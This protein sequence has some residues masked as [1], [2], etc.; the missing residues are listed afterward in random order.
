MRLVTLSGV[1]TTQ[2]TDVGRYLLLMDQQEGR[3]E[4]HFTDEE[5]KKDTSGMFYSRSTA[6]AFA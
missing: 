1:R 6:P 2:L 3:K 5:K 4:V